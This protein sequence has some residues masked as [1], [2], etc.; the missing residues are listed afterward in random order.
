MNGVG[1]GKKFSILAEYIK[2]AN[3]LSFY[4]LNEMIKFEFPPDVNAILKFNLYLSLFMIKTKEEK[5]EQEI[6]ELPD[7]VFIKIVNF[8]PYL[9]INNEIETDFQCLPLLFYF[10]TMV[11]RLN[12]YPP[13]D[14]TGFFKDRISD[15][16]DL[17]PNKFI[18]K[19]ND[20]INF[21]QDSEK[22]R[23]TWTEDDDLNPDDHGIYANLNLKTF[24]LPSLNVRV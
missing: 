3:R 18:L 2:K 16:R 12:I 20:L 23:I 13:K 21:S 10:S 7:V 24:V 6:V 11:K 17:S 19:I 8:I 5:I 9:L 1:K 22:F 4:D 14:V 15:M